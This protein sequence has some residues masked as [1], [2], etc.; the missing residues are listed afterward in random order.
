[1]VLLLGL[2]VAPICEAVTAKPPGYEWIY[3]GTRLW[4]TAGASTS[5][6][7]AVT[8]TMILLRNRVVPGGRLALVS[9]FI[10]E[11]A[12]SEP[13]TRP[14]LSLL[15]CQ[16]NATLHFEFFSDSEAE[17]LFARWED[18][19][20]TPTDTLLLEP[21]REEAMWGNTPLREDQM[22]SW[23][24]HQLDAPPATP[25][26]CSA[27]GPAYEL[28]LRTMPDH[29]FVVWMGGAGV[30]AYQYGHHGTPAAADVHLTACRPPPD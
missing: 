5:D 29:Q 4:T 26:G 27:T 9:G 18:T 19:T 6:S 3:H 17:R 25:A 11:I 21:L 28:A 7:G 24:V 20:V 13:S 14:R 1:M 12:W 30:V 8:W 23:V 2:A 15:A 10:S 22:Y 16:G